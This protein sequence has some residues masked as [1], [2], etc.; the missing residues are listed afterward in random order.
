MKF[1]DFRL[2]Y[3][4]LGG[5]MPLFN[6]C[7]FFILAELGD[8]LSTWVL[9]QWAESNQTSSGSASPTVSSWLTPSTLTS[10]KLSSTGPSLRN[11]HEDLSSEKDHSKE[12][13]LDHYIL[14]Y[15]L[16]GLFALAFQSIRET[17]FACRS[18]I[19]GRKIY[20]RLISTLLNAQGKLGSSFSILRYC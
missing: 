12:K 4:C 6:S 8:V 3:D 1:G 17:Y 10:T 2:Y 5:F 13:R 15:L 19:A 14:L 11:F 18:I 9:E 7:I 20:E 16:A